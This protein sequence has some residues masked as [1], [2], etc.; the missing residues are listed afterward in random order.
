MNKKVLLAATNND[1][2]AKE[3]KQIL[4]DFFQEI[5]SL[6]DLGLNI[7]PEE[8]GSTFL[9]NAQIKARAVYNHIKGT[10]A[11]IADD[12][13]LIVPALNDEPGI[14]S[15]RYAGIDA[16][17]TKNNQK[18]LEKLKGMTDRR[19]YFICT[20]VLILP[21]G[22]EITAQGKV[23]GTILEKPEGGGGFGYDPIFFSDELKK[24]FGFAAPSEKNAISHRARALNELKQKFILEQGHIDD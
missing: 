20:V 17:D 4:G 18:L 12:S 9:E 1:G 21:D 16:D 6:K 23:N 8:N 14:M 15:A 13:G 7:N 11:V 2:K 19:A 3:I 5:K 10:M 24:S 22:K